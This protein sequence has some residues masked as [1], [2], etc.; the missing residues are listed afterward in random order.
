MQEE[1]MK[2]TNTIIRTQNFGEYFF[3]E[4]CL[5]TCQQKLSGVSSHNAFVA[6]QLEHWLYV[7]FNL[8][9]FKERKY[10]EKQ[11]EYSK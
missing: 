1:K 7:C 8:E 9:I 4:I 11:E 3:H 6:E 10:L 5:F 2:K